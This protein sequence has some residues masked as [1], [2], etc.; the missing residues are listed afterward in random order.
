M[1]LSSNSSF[2]EGDPIILTCS[3]QNVWGSLSVSWQWTPP[4]STSSSSSPT[5]T[6]PIQGSE[7]EESSPGPEPVELASVER[8]GTVRLGPAYLERGSYGEVR[9]TRERADIY[10]LALYN[11][12]P[13][14]AGQYRCTVTEWT[15]TGPEPNSTWQQL[16][17]KSATKAITVKSVGKSPHSQPQTD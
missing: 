14:D 10:T 16:G 3:V 1:S 6:T 9:A 4:S 17:E 8:D 15:R 11:A 13:T 7:G 5:A 2:D 12:Y